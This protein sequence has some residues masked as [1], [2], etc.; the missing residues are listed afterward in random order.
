MATIHD[1]DIGDLVYLDSFAGL[2]P[3]KVIHLGPKDLVHVVITA[4]RGP[5][6]K[7]FQDV[8]PARQVV[9]REW[10]VTRGGQYRI[11]EGRRRANPWSSYTHGCE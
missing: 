4:T 2:V 11:I 6:K 5:Y 3:A 7:G 8:L 10:V 9:K 1:F